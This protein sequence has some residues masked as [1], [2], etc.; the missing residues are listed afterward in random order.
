MPK[1]SVLMAAYNTERYIGAAIESIL[2]QTMKD[3]EFLIIDDKSTDRTAKIIARYAKKDRRI[4]FVQNKENFGLTKNLNILLEK[5]RGEYIARMDA[6]DV[7]MPT[8][9]ARQVAFLKKHK[10][11]SL[12]GTW[13]EVIDKNDR[14]IGKLEYVTAH[15]D[16]QRNMTERSQ[17]IHPS[18]MFRK[19]IVK[20]IGVY[21]EKFRSA[22]D[23][24]YFARVMSQFTV[25]NMPEKLMRYRWDF[26]QNEGFKNNRRQ[27]RNGW[28]TRWR[29]FTKYHWPIR[30]LIYTIKPAIAFCIPSSW[31][32]WVVK[33]RAGKK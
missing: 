21:D 24:E 17:I 16:I 28:V 2:K 26:D 22:Q 14:V 23:Y 8:R 11:I 18:V 7:A 4:H 33:R 20:K 19:S 29:M 31:R 25:A 13:A 1:I 12:V 30:Y 5:A 15:K 32:M 6:D 9:F 3:F 27:E 10:D